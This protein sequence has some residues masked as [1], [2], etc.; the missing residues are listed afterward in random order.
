MRIHSVLF[1]CFDG[2]GGA[3]PI[4][5]LS[6]IILFAWIFSN[7]RFTWYEANVD[8]L[9]VSARSFKLPGRCTSFSDGIF[10]GGN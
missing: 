8:R 7:V 4:L 2:T 5:G 6:V 1:V 9:D 3:K 10:S